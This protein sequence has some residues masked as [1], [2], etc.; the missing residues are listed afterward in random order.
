MCTNYAMMKFASHTHTLAQWFPNLILVRL[1]KVPGNRVGK[2]CPNVHIKTE[3]YFGYYYNYING[4]NG[5][6]HGLA[7]GPQVI[8]SD[9]EWS[10]GQLSLLGLVL[11]VPLLSFKQKTAA[12]RSQR[13]QGLS[14]PRAWRQTAR[15]A[16]PS[17]SPWCG[18]SRTGWWA[19]VPRFWSY[20]S[21]CSSC[22]AAATETARSRT[23][24]RWC[25][26][27]SSDVRRRRKTR[28]RQL[29]KT[30]LKGTQ[31]R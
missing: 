20:S 1:P 7:S 13:S 14:Q 4:S 6:E 18:W 19:S 12:Y 29:S 22:P 2:H 28:R 8:L 26:T 11:N 9:F 5:P 15:A 21:S 10:R 27:A 3:I 23:S 31:G 17:G 30:G 24:P 16:C 25:G